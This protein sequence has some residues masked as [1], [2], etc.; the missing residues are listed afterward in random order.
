[1]LELLAMA[2]VDGERWCAQLYAELRDERGTL[3]GA[4]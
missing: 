1:M 4:A 2:R 3:G